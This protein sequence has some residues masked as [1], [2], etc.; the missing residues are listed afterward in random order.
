VSSRWQNKVGLGDA[1]LAR[2]YQEKKKSIEDFFSFCRARVLTASRYALMAMMI[3][4]VP[5]DVRAAQALASPLKRPRHMERTSASIWRT[6]GNTLM[7]SGFVHTN[8]P[9]VFSINA[10]YAYTDYEPLPTQGEEEGG[11][12]TST[13]APPTYS[14]PLQRPS[15]MRVLGSPKWAS[16]RSM[17]SSWAS[18]MPLAGIVTTAACLGGSY[19]PRTKQKK[20]KTHT[21]TNKQTNKHTATDS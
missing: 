10:V 9:Y 2:L 6:P 12:R 18:G 1:P 20:T 13:L 17:S 19:M 14:V 3:L 7:C 21:H 4:S 11:G 5:P 16:S 8:M 15:T